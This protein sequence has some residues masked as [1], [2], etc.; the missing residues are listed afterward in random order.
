MKRISVF[1]G[2]QVKEGDWDY[3]QALRLGKLI[4]GA[5]YTVLTGGYLGTMEAISRGVA[6]SGGHVI[7]VTC[8]EIEAWR[9]VGMNPWVKEELRCSTL[10]ERI[11]T[12]IDQCDAAFVL[13]GGPGTL[14]EAA[15]MW[16]RL[17]I[18]SINP[19]PLII[20]GLG[21]CS[22]FELLFHEMDN[23]IPERQR[24]LLA[25]SSDVEHAFG[26]LQKIL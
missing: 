10:L 24:K 20:V 3:S 14:A 4:G 25:F 1:G 5:G 18:E 7:G 13:P 22:I 9:P 12:L 2:T 17:I 26:Q 15:F 23:F 8:V 11:N 16:N 6:E 19:R 21:W